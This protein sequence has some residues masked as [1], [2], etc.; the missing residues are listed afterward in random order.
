MPLY[1]SFLG[2]SVA[3]LSLG[4]FVAAC[5]DDDTLSTSNDD[6]GGGGST[7]NGP[8][9]GGSGGDATS[10]GG[11]GA[12]D[13]CLNED[14]QT[15]TPPNP[16]HNALSLDV[17]VIS[18]TIVDQNGAP[19]ADMIA[20]V[21]GT[22]VCAVYGH[23]EA[24]G[25][26]S[27]DAGMTTILDP[28]LLFGDGRDFAKMGVLVDSV[29]EDFGTLN[30][31]RL[32][33][34]SQG[35]AFCSGSDATSNGVTVSVPAG[36]SINE[37][38]TFIYADGERGFRAAVANA[39]DVVNPDMP[40]SIEVLVATA[41]I[42]ALICPAAKVTFPNDNGWAEGT[43]VHVYLYGSRLVG[44]HFVPYGEWGQISMATVTAE[45][46]VTDEGQEI[47]VLGTFGLDPQL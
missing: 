2:F 28:L 47:G 13:A 34:V 31:I 23:T 29:S 27:G 40:A 4:L 25:S 10:S 32:P 43:A 9:S 17:G 36:A 37:I 22:N 15:C 7:S 19:A 26:F 38:D 18:A 3:A 11:S 24:D 33:P 20:D 1:R 30:V 12:G 16:A 41:P 46:I 45:G 42:D 8:G 35:A 6:D 14:A 44:G 5:S 21:C 39:A